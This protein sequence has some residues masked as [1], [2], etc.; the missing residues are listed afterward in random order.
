LRNRLGDLYG[1]LTAAVVALPLG[2]AFGVAA[3]APLGPEH[4]ATGAIVGLLGCIIAGFFAALLG[5]TPTQV[6]GPTGPMTVVVTAFVARIVAGHGADL[7]LVL[8]SV[9]IMVAVGGVVEILIGLLGGGRLVKFIPYPVVAGFMNGIAVIIVLGQ[10]EPALGTTGGYEAISMANAL[11]AVGVCIVTVLAILASRR[12]APVLPASLVGLAA[13]IAGYRVF[14]ELGLSPGTVSG[15]ALLIGDIPNPFHSVGDLKRI[16]PAL[17][18]GQLT[19]LPRADI[20][21]AVTAGTVLGLLGAIDSLLTSIVADARTRTRHD[22][23]R[24]LIGQGIANIASGFGGGLPGAGAT[25]RTLVNIGAGARTRLSGMTHALVILV[26][27]AAAGGAAAWIPLAALAGVLFVTAVG[28]VDK[29]SLQLV[30]RRRVRGEFG[31]MIAVTVITV[32]VDLITAVGV[33][34]AIAAVLFIRQQ[35]QQPV[36]YRRLRG[37]QVLSRS[38]RPR[39]DLARLRETG[40]RTL[41]YE[42]E[43]S[44]FFGSTDRLAQTVEADLGTADHFI[45]DLARVRDLDLSGAQVL[46]ALVGQIKESGD[47]SL[48]GLRELEHRTPFSVHAMLRELGVLSLVGSDHVF[49]NLDRALEASEERR[50]GHVPGRDAPLSIRQFDAFAELDDDELAT[51]TD[52]LIERHIP[53]GTVVFETHDP[54][55]DLVLVRSGKLEL[56]RSDA[57]HDYRLTALLPGSIIGTRSLLRQQ[58]ARIAGRVRAASDC[59]VYVLA[60][61]FLDVAQSEHPE[62]FVHL[63]QGMLHSAMEQVDL[64]MFEVMQLER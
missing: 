55:R 54:V 17:H 3:F 37:D 41:V 11:P 18:L 12:L 58:D 60:R 15:N 63:Q 25:V 59:E 24:E 40:A 64:L 26:L 31:V 48:S 45:F 6:T 16:V 27:V 51:F 50:L 44:L 53:R 38:L 5:G 43:G 34:C 42:L 29:Y 57:S 28:M 10:I 35:V 9:A 13:G 33:G 23:R 46:A 47:V 39:R 62:A 8:A 21:D 61:A 22:S 36:V 30:K 56:I 20:V 4:A 19:A 1:G 52:H 7:S 49:S 2:L 14:A 32:A